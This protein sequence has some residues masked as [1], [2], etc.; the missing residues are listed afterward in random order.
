VSV[1]DLTEAQA[2]DFLAQ[3][4]CS[5]RDAKAVHLLI[6]GHLPYLLDSAVG[7][8]C[9]SKLS[10]DGLKAYF[11]E[12]VRSGFKHADVEL[13]CDNGCA[14][15]AACAIRDEEWAH[16]G[17]KSARALLLKEKLVHASLKEKIYKIDS[18][19]VL[20]YLER[21]CACNNTGFVV[22]PS[23]T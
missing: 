20:C 3:L 4:N 1:G 19:F 22:V 5:I 10:L 14:C 13:D 9:D 18:R 8:F 15:K 23:C 21:E 6:V 7:S 11:T 12:L 2:L 16:V 17:L